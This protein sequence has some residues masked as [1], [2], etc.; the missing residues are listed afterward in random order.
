MA[1]VLDLYT[2]LAPTPNNDISSDASAPLISGV[3]LNKFC[4]K[5]ALSRRRDDN[6]LA[7]IAAK[8]KRAVG[9]GGRLNAGTYSAWPRRCNHHQSLRR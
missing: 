6:S 8:K 7:E 4:E 9:T 3:R 1:L 2:V 5:S